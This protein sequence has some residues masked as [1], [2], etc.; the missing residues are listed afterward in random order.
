MQELFEVVLT[1]N[2]A[3]FKNPSLLERNL[4]GQCRTRI[5]Y[6]DPMASWQKGRLEWNH[7][8]I[9]YIL[10]RGRPFTSLTKAQVITMM[11]HINNTARSSLNGRTP[12]ELASLLLPEALLKWAGA[13]A[14]P[15]DDVLLKLRLLKMVSPP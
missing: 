2:G 7:E 8:F 15:H 5:F 11:N 1:D 3:E 10:P 12:F 14:F 9:R 4:S 6:C 13:V